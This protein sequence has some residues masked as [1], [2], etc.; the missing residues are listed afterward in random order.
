M[1]EKDVIIDTEEIEEFLFN[2]LIK[3]GFAPGKKEVEE[4]ADIV[5]DYLISIDVIEDVTKSE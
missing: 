3:R 2:E 4:I 1:D 5:F